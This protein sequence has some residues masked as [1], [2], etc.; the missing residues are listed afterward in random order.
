MFFVEMQLKKQK[1]K[2]DFWVP[3]LG[4]PNRYTGLPNGLNTSL[5]NDL[6]FCLEIKFYEGLVSTQSKY[7]VFAEVCQGGSFW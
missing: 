4:C 7:Q 2:S 6:F 3:E 5:I 1:L